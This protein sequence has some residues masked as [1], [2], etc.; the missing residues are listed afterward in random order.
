MYYCQNCVSVLQNEGL[1]HSLE[2][3]LLIVTSFCAL[4]NSCFSVCEP[5]VNS[6]VFYAVIT[7]M[8]LFSLCYV[9]HVEFVAFHLT[10]FMS[11]WY[12][13]HLG[14]LASES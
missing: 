10:I 14:V 2:C 9:S 5:V 11:S 12:F 7:S 13:V 8:M 6:Q 1:G 4:H 3:M